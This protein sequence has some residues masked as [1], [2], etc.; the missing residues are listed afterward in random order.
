MQCCKKRAGFVVAHVFIINWLTGRMYYSSDEEPM[1]VTAASVRLA[2]VGSRERTLVF[3]SACSHFKHLLTPNFRSKWK[4]T[5]KLYNRHTKFQ[6][7]GL[8]LH[9]L[10]LDSDSSP[11][12]QDLWLDF[13]NNDLT[14]TWALW[15]G[16]PLHRVYT[17]LE[18]VRRDKI[19]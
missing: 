7:C 12:F 8:E 9:D 11:K 4:Y 5:V 17:G 19:Q 13:D 16:K 2:W 6:I 15:L 10:K 18:P 1:L 14:W 3:F